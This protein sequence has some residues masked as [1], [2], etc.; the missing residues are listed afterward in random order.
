MGVEDRYIVVIRSDMAGTRLQITDLVPNTS[1]QNLVIDP[2]GQSKY[3]T[4]F[5]ESTVV[6]S[7]TNPIISPVEQ[8]GLA[9]YLIDNVE[10]DPGSTDEAL[11][12]AEANAAAAAI[13]ARADAGDSLLLADINTILA[14]EGGGVTDLDGAG[15]D[16]ASTGTVEEV[17]KI[18]AGGRYVLPAGSVLETA[19]AFNTVR[20]GDFDDT[21][22]APTLNTGAFI[23]S[24]NQGQLAGFKDADYSFLNTTGAAVVVYDNTGAVI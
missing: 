22:F 5:D 15:A 16:S 10:A 18:L 12:F 11:T 8:T 13:I 20:Q 3:L 23:I 21:F 1:Q 19:G 24:N 6:T 7:G 9:A 2:P 14:A 17:L 4:R